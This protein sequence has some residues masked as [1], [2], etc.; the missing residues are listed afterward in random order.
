MWADTKT[1]HRMTQKPSQMV[2]TMAEPDMSLQA[3]R[4]RRRQ[5]TVSQGSAAPAPHA[6]RPD[7]IERLH[8]LRMQRIE[9]KL[10]RVL[11]EIAVH[12]A[13]IRRR[14]MMISLLGVPAGLMVAIGLMTL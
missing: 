1:A 5:D 14:S 9:Q 2:D 13:T 4:A 12:A 10:D 6:R 11:H 8:D 3:R 7:T